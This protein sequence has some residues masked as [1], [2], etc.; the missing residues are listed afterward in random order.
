M[1]DLN[2]DVATEIVVTKVY[3]W[4]KIQERFV[5][6]KDTISVDKKW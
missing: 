3:Y 6:D 1:A 2:R 5:S 4:S